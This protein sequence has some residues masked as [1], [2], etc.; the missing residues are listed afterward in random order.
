MS[1]AAASVYATLAFMNFLN[2]NVRGRDSAGGKSDLP[3]SPSRVLETLASTAPFAA[4]FLLNAASSEKYK[5]SQYNQQ[6]F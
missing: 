6:L 4:F 3:S 1:L 5:K 2:S